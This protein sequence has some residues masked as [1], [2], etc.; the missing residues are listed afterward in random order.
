MLDAFAKVPLHSISLIDA[1]A[2]NWPFGIGERRHSRDTRCEAT[3]GVGA[4]IGNQS[5]REGDNP[6]SIPRIIANYRAGRLCAPER[7]AARR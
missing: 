6:R 7:D 1:R 4:L 5:S 2:I 3:R